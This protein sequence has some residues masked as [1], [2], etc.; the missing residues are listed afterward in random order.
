MAQNYTG[1][2]GV[3]QIRLRRLWAPKLGGQM[4]RLTS[5]NRQ[6]CDMIV[7]ADGCDLSLMWDSGGG[8]RFGMVG[9][10]RFQTIQMSKEQ[11]IALLD[12]R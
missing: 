5:K 3:C 4:N 1:L 6:T 2:P 9:Y 10:E 7:S 11:V 12:H 8:F